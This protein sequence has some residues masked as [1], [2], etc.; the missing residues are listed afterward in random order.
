[1]SRA[2]RPKGSKK[3]KGNWLLLYQFPVGAL[4]AGLLRTTITGRFGALESFYWPLCKYKMAR[5]LNGRVT[6]RK[7]NRL[8]RFLG[9]SKSRDQED[10]LK[11]CSY[12][13]KDS[14][15]WEQAPLGL[16]RPG[17]TRLMKGVGFFLSVTENS[18]KD[19]PEGQATVLLLKRCLPKLSITFSP[20]IF[21][22]CLTQSC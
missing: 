1:M 3:A 13:A 14:F 5:E 22:H 7:F 21:V 8:G 12:C 10:W 4:Q 17:F 11:M 6:P 9:I 16:S 15:S 18:A 2:G 19:K 20:L